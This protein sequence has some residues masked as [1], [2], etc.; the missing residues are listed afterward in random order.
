MTT[1]VHVPEG[2]D[3]NV[4]GLKTASWSWGTGA[5]RVGNFVGSFRAAGAGKRDERIEQV[6][7]RRSLRAKREKKS[8]QACEQ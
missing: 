1:H 8:A 3:G 6:L 7:F 4:R 5:P 2:I